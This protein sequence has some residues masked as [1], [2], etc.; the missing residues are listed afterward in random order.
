MTSARS[1]NPELA[2]ARDTL[3]R[4]KLIPGIITATYFIINIL[5][6]LL[7]YNSFEDVAT[8]AMDTMKGF[9]ILNQLTVLVGCL[10]AAC[11]VFGYLHRAEAA[12]LVHSRPVT[13]TQLFRST[14]LTGL[15][16]TIVPVVITALFFLLLQGSQTTG[17][18][19]MLVTGLDIPSVTGAWEVTSGINI[20]GWMIDLIVLSL[21]TYSTACF[22][23]ILAGTGL[24]Q[25]LL[26]L[27]LLGAPVAIRGI[28]S[29]YMEVFLK[30]YSNP[31]AATELGSLFSMRYLSPYMFILTRGVYPMQSSAA[32]LIAYTVIAVLLAAAS[33]WIYKRLQLENIGRSIT[34]PYVA[35]I[36]VILLSFITTSLVLFIVYEISSS[37]AVV[38]S[39]ILATA[40]C[41]PV[42][43]MIADQTFRIFT[44]KNLKLL[45]IYAVIM[46]IALAL[47]AWDVTGYEKRV[48]DAENVASIEI[49]NANLDNGRW[50]SSDQPDLI[51]KTIDLHRAAIAADPADI[52]VAA[53]D[54]ETSTENFG[55]VYHL[56]NGKIMERQYFNIPVDAVDPEL[57]SLYDDKTIRSLE[58][59]DLAKIADKRSTINVCM[60]SKVSFISDAAL[61]EGGDDGEGWYF[62]SVP[63]ELKEEFAEAI[64]KD[65]LNWTFKERM[66][67]ERGGEAEGTVDITYYSSE[68][69]SGE[70]L[71]YKSVQITAADRNTLAFLEAHPEIFTEENLV[72]E[73]E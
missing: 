52:N 37:S 61:I 44:K 31:N 9:N 17:G 62:Y 11:A 28:T 40:V 6:L 13:R 2:W 29:G 66:A 54:Y 20:F 23:G 46:V 59:I 26:A 45:G 41:F 38:L 51:A 43:C 64:N 18:K 53:E 58:T 65:I 14:Y 42:Y 27:F 70:N 63:V 35:E 69:S 68:N 1:I 12:V 71:F 33:L 55:I 24:I 36:L 3:K 39:V 7:K 30:G 47:S 67:A 60:Y 21:I 4:Y 48:P 5:P 10:M 56:A 34:V 8:Y 19:P 49:N 15:L 72:P 73:V 25:A 50:L 57:A 22:A 32:P 16:F